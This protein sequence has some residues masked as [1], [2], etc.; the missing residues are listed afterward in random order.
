[1][2]GDLNVN[3]PT[4]RGAMQPS[5]LGAGSPAKPPQVG[6]TYLTTDFNQ[7]AETAKVCEEDRLGSR[8]RSSDVSPEEL[9]NKRI[10]TTLSPKAAREGVL[11]DAGSSQALEG[12]LFEAP[13]LQSPSSRVCVEAL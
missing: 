3:T 10:K 9:P 1:M 7:N 2:L 4:G 6:E 11:L 12:G 8:K 13:V 5:K